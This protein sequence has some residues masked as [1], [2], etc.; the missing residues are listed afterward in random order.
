MILPIPERHKSRVSRR[1]NCAEMDVTEAESELLRNLCAAE[2]L[3]E[4]NLGLPLTKNLAQLQVLACDLKLLQDPLF[5]SDTNVLIVSDGIE[6]ADVRR[7]A[8]ALAACQSSLRNRSYDNIYRIATAQDMA[9]I[10]KLTGSSTPCG[11][12]L[13]A[14]S[15]RRTYSLSTNKSRT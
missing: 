15:A 5:A 13:L 12:I 11:S 1:K 6:G 3:P 10:E 14:K 2:K 8:L 4:T 9:T 7:R